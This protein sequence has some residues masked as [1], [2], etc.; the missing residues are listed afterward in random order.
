MENLSRPGINYLQVVLFIC[1]SATEWNIT[2]NFH[3][4]YLQYYQIR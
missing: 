3:I 1:G 2:I 4:K